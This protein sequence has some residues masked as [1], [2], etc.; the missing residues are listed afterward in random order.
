MKN[1]SVVTL[2]IKEFISDLGL[3]EDDVKEGTLEIIAQAVA[4]GVIGGLSTLLN[5]YTGYNNV[6]IRATLEEM[7]NEAEEIIDDIEGE[8]DED[9]DEE[10]EGNDGRVTG[11]VPEGQK[12]AAETLVNEALNLSLDVVE[13]NL[14]PEQAYVIQAQ[15]QID[16][17]QKGSPMI[18]CQSFRK[19]PTKKGH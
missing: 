17:N 8:D 13:Q 15:S 9:E 6:T 16:T 12:V 10:G 14:T 11:E 4:H 19:L 2:L 1:P 5:G 3:D 18:D 7:L